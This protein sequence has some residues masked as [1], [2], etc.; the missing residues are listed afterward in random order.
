MSAIDLPFFSE[1]QPASWRGVPFAVTGST[2]RVGRRNVVHEYP[3]RDD[4]WIEDMGRAGRRITLTGFLVQ[5]AAYGGTG[6]VIAQ[7]AA[8]I[9]AC[10]TQD[11]DDGE[12]VHASLGRLT[13]SLLDF[14]CEERA[15]RGRVF[16]LRFSFIE[17]GA[18]QF[19]TL[20]IA[21]QAQ[22]A[23][24]VV[25]AFAATAQDFYDRMAALLTTP[26]IIGEIERTARAFVVDAQAIT[27]RAT[28]LVA[29]VAT[30]AGNYGRFVGEF[31]AS[32]KNASTTI[33]QLVGAGAQA[34]E[35]VTQSGAL[36]TA[37]AAL[38]DYPGMA[39][40]V[41]TLVTAVQTANPDPHQAVQSLVTL[42]AQTTA[43]AR[44]TAGLTAANAQAIALYRRDAVIA[45]ASSTA[46]YA[47]TSYDDA[48]A[49]RSTVCD[50]I[51]AEIVLAADA[52]DDATYEA[53]QALETAV[54]QDLTTR[55]FSGGTA[56][57]NMQTVSTPQ[58]MPLIVLAQRLYQDVARYDGLLQ[59]A[60]PVHPA[61]PP[62]AFRASNE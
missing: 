26:A 41:Q 18:Q 51:E 16:E 62:V 4:V 57:A 30:L 40:A 33:D 2:L 22:T 47:L 17:G 50:A 48:Q 14:E 54:V 25:A 61:F 29:M 27:Q 52:G 44:A 35:A 23:L 42:Q 24:S 49:L 34:R 32:V 1:L 56:Q 9:A 36:L 37:R 13:V 58:P 19:P 46:A 11:D 45:L 55:G 7:R 38:A 10:E 59:Q 43:Q 53:L 21:T 39:S 15:E 6:D 8:M 28:S 60:A 3:Y 5:D 12:L 31:T 20:A